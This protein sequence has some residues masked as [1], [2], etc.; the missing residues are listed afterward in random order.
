MCAWEWEF[1]WEW[2]LN[3]NKRGNGNNSEWEWEWSRVKASQVI[4]NTNTPQFVI[5]QCSL[6]LSRRWMVNVATGRALCVLRSCD[7]VTLPLCCWQL[8]FRFA[9]SF[10]Y[11]RTFVVHNRP[12]GMGMGGNGKQFCELNGNGN[13]IWDFLGMGMGMG[14]TW[15]EWEG[16][17]IR[18]AIPAHL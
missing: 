6:M 9:L 11:S 10:D 17:G 16:M 1:P 18:R 13:W 12:M 5:L 8:R 7:N 15:W 2:E 3:W 14:M 4:S